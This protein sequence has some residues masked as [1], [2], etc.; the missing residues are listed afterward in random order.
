MRKSRRTTAEVVVIV[1]GVLALVGL[2]NQAAPAHT[3]HDHTD[4]EHRHGG[5]LTEVRLP[6]GEVITTHGGDSE[7]LA[8][9]ATV[10]SERTVRARRQVR[11]VRD[12]SAPAFQ[13]LYAYPRGH[14][15]RAGSAVASIRDTIR[16]ANGILAV[17]AEES[18]STW[19]AKLRVRCDA[20]GRIRV[21]SYAVAN[22][23]DDAVGEDL[24]Q[25][26]GAGRAAGFTDG[27]S[28]YIVFWDSAIPGMCGQGQLRL[29]DRRIENNANNQGGA[30]AVLY[31]RTCW[32]PSVAMHEIGHTMGAVQNSAP[33]S[34]R[35]GHCNQEHD[36]MC[37][38]DGGP[39]GRLS[40][41]T[42][43]CRLAVFD[44]GHN[45]YF[46]VGRARGYLATHWNVG[47]S[48]NRYLAFVR[49]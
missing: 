30:Y 25:I 48:K 39:S 3:G 22:P 34:T 26:V 32:T 13:V 47:W 6:D 37:Y 38:A 40:N 14:G 33:R 49:R 29:D 43:S 18:S 7:A 15:N 45:D 21:R 8:A 12:A 23:G 46:K 24:A 42:T 28:K 4:H 1:M 2:L 17:S 11:C 35:T 5:Q 44:C 20:A 36:V 31:G 9:V 19:S 10:S 27:P 41:I 16:L